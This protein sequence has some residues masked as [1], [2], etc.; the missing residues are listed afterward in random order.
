LFDVEDQP[1]PIPQ[2]AVDP[3]YLA[4]PV[5]TDDGGSGSSGSGSSGSDGGS[6]GSDGSSTEVV[7]PDTKPLP[8]E[9]PTQP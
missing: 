5:A 9:E 7:P 3:A 1:W 6:T 8:P 4:P 2:V